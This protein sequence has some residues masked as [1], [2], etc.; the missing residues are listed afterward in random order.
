MPQPSQPPESP[1]HAARSLADVLALHAR[2]RPGAPALRFEGETLD[3]AALHVRVR[4]AAAVAWHVWGVRPGDRVAWL[5][6]NH[7]G[8][9]VLLFALAEIGAMLLPLNFRLAPPEWDAL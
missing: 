3:Y 7:P 1:L 5:G 4:Q 2:A 6:G 9:L 8:Q